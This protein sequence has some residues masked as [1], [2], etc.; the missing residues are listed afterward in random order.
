M[1]GCSLLFSPSKDNQKLVELDSAIAIRSLAS[2]AVQQNFQMLLSRH[3]TIHHA[4]KYTILPSL[5]AFYAN[6]HSAARQSVK[7][8]AATT[9][10]R[11]PVQLSN[12]RSPLPGMEN[13]GR[14]V[15]DSMTM[16]D[17]QTRDVTVRHSHA[18]PAQWETRMPLA[19]EN[20]MHLQRTHAVTERHHQHY[21]CKTL[22]T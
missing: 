4:D 12:L 5:F 15:D 7:T 2:R 14:M 21:V 11:A 20:V 18:K 13:L 3:C 16:K 17:I 8:R 22:A 1:L 6:Q 10:Q 9:T 19:A